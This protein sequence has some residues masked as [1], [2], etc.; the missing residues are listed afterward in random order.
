MRSPKSRFKPS[1]Y[2]VRGFT[3]LELMIAV[4]LGALLLGMVMAFTQG[5]AGATQA[6]VFRSRLSLETHRIIN[7]ITGELREAGKSTLAAAPIAPLGSS[8]LS[9]R[10]AV[11][12]TAGA[13]VWSPERRIE[14]QSDPNDPA[15]GADDDN[16]G[17]TDE[18]DIVLVVT[19]AF[20]AETSSRLGTNIAFYLEGETANA[21]DD[22]GNQLTDERGLS[23]VLDGDSLVVRITRMG[24]APSGL[25][26]LHTSQTTVS[27]RNE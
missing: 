13:I 18:C 2:G 17:L 27:L 23:F 7:R 10:Q 22:N 12:F 9:F 5:T 16:D 1:S 15:N 6:T 3:V 4:A 19:D 21:A 11:G 24:A 25:V 26:L 14:L 20:G 8:Q